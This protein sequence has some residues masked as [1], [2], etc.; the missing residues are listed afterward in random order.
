[1]I[2]SLSRAV[3]LNLSPS[4]IL[5]G[6]G[7]TAATVEQHLKKID[8]RHVRVTW[9]A[10][11]GPAFALSV[12]GATVASIIDE[13][14]AGSHA[15]SGDLGNRWLHDHSVGSGPFTIRKY[16]PTRR[17]SSMPTRFRPVLHRD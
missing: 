6:L 11:V 8:E 4:F 5:N 2:W 3:K 12:L 15:K 17:W 9:S 14:E 7:W 1:V 13:R 16:I 10:P